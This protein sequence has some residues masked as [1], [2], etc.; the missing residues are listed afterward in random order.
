[1]L[2]SNVLHTQG[3]YIFEVLTDSMSPTIRKGAIIRTHELDLKEV[4]TRGIYIVLTEKGGGI[5]RIS[6]DIKPEE[7]LIKIS[8]DNARYSIFEVFRPDII[9]I[10]RADTI[11]SQDITLLPD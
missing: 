9:Q 5:C 2:A 10:F 8:F 1:M 6:H 11:I 3:G 7:E 4:I